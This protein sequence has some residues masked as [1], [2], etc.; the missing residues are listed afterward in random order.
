MSARARSGGASPICGSRRDRRSK[1]GLVWLC[2]FKSE[3]RAT[4][5]TAVAQ[6]A[7]AQGLGCLRFDYSGHGQSEGRFEDGTVSRW[8]EEARSVFER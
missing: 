4:K 5:A 2:G 6:W 3:M 8:L 7:A 1:P